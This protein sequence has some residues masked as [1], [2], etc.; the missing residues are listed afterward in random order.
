MQPPYTLPQIP[1]SSLLYVSPE[2]CKPSTIA[3]TIVIIP[4]R[5]PVRPFGFTVIGICPLAWTLPTYEE[6]LELWG[7]NLGTAFLAMALL[8]E[9]Q[10]ADEAVG[11]ANVCLDY[12]YDPN[13]YKMLYLF[14][15]TY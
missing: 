4:E 12:T 9:V 13:E 11:I 5:Q 3:T 8:H 6:S 1:L 10:H 7:Q 14:K 15:R 2:I